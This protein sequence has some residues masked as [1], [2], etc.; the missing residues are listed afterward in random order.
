MSF[1]K[2]IDEARNAY[3]TGD[4]RAAARAHISERIADEANERHTG[5]GSQY[6]GEFVYG[7]LDGIITTF[8]VV[9]GVV[10]ANLSPSIILVLGLANLL[11]D[12]FSMATGSF[13]STRSE[14][15]YYARER[16]REA[17]EVENFPEGEKEELLEIFRRKGHSEDDAQQ[18]TEI[19]SRKRE[20]WIDTMM[21]DELGLTT[22][23][24]NPWLNGLA[25]F[26]AFLIAGIVPLLV[27]LVGLAVPIPSQTAFLLSVMLSGLA[28]FGLGAAKVLVTGQRTLRSGTE[29][30]LVGGLAAGVAYVVGALLRGLGVEG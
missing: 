17:W 10:G 12:G 1:S 24:R 29:M 30:L 25:T 4:K 14:R 26:A 2:R 11:A 18:L 9:S 7:G 23:D 20:H 5:A 16:A 28:L 27:Y 3:R 21:V 13:L 19:V 6:I 22:D 15:E 8:A